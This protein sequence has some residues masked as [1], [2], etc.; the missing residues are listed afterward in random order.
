MDTR[1]HVVQWGAGQPRKRTSAANWRE[2]VKWNK[3]AVQKGIRYRVFCASLADVFDNEI[4]PAWRA[5]LFALIQSTPNL[6]WLLLTKRISN[7][8][9]MIEAA[10]I[11][12]DI[13][14]AVDFAAWPWP[15]VWIGAT[16]CNQEEANRDIPKLLA[17]PAAKHFLSMEPLLGSVQLD[18]KWMRRYQSAQ[19]VEVQMFMSPIDWVIV[20]GES[21]PKARATHPD[22]VRALRDQCKAARVAFHFK[23]WGEW[24]P[25]ERTPL[26]HAKITMPGQNRDLVAWTDSRRIGRKKAGRSLDGLE[27]DQLP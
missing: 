6:D 7:A 20:G 8:S 26:L 16:V 9:K 4:D 11:E 17:L 25:V 1:L 3:E 23:Q 13:G 15:N 22:W 19:G 21:G 14:Y 27:W 24:A 2:P 12:Q 5:D 10:M 18:P